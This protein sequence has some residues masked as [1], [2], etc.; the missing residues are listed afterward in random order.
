M[1]PGKDGI[2]VCRQLKA[3]PSLPFMPVILVTA[4]SDPDDI[5]AASMPAETNMLRSRRPRGAGGAGPLYPPR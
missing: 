5:V 1:M 2:A 3:D 4:R